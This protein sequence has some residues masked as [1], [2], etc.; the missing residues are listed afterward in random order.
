M[1]KIAGLTLIAFVLSACAS[2]PYDTG[3]TSADVPSHVDVIN[4]K[5]IFL[6]GGEAPD[7]LKDSGPHQK[8][9]PLEEKDPST[10]DV[11]VLAVAK[12]NIVSQLTNLG[13]TIVEGDTT[14]SDVKM[15]FAV[16]YMPE[17]VLFVHRQVG[18]Q[19]LV[20]SPNGNLLFRLGAGKVSAAGAFTSMV[21]SRDELV[22]E[23]AREAVVNVINELRKG[24][25]D[26][27]PV[28]KQHKQTSSP[29]KPEQ[30][31]SPQ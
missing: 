10:N 22:S 9:D 12:A 28:S 15:S 29:N 21:Q 7:P 27:N 16:S 23:C 1:K 26:N 13:Y 6:Y 3:R 18:V 25:L 2:S 4:L 31:E 11:E 19:G 8:P 20:Y 5:K 17:R 30:L 24:T 14:E